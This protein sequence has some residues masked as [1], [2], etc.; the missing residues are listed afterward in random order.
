M[1]AGLLQKLTRDN[2]FF[3]LLKATQPHF[4]SA[5]YRLWA[6]EAVAV[7]KLM[8]LVLETG[9][10]S[11][12]HPRWP[13]ALNRLVGANPQ[14]AD[15][16]ALLAHELYPDLAY[17]AAIFGFTTLMTF[18]GEDF[19]SPDEMAEYA[20]GVAN[21]LSAQGDPLE[22]IH[23]YLPLVLGGIAINAQIIMPGEDPHDTMR[24]YARARDS[25]AG[26]ADEGNQFIFDL[27]DKLIAL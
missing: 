2:V 8:T 23:A 6:G 12:A 1:M 13:E 14:A 18:T 25:R 27:A 24:L 9:P 20:D 26:E 11:P 7:A 22:L 4:E 21:S 5:Q 17:D 3:P 16:E 19:G 10:L 15:I